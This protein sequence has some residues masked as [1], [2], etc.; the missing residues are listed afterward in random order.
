MSVPQK[1][2]DIERKLP[3]VSFPALAME[4]VPGPACLSLLV[5]E[6]NDSETRVYEATLQI[7]V[8]ESVTIDRLKREIK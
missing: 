8:R 4:R 5:K 6:M 3:L 1:H 2:A 7:F